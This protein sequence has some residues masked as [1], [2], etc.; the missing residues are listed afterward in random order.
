VFLTDSNLQLPAWV[1][2]DQGSGEILLPNY[3]GLEATGARF[4]ELM[5]LR[6]AT[7]S[8]GLVAYYVTMCITDAGTE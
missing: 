6:E 4:P 8:K 2:V 5:E 1:Q 3:K 7:K